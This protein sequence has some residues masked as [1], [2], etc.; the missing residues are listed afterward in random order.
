M[1]DMK[2]IPVIYYQDPHVMSPKWW[3]NLVSSFDGTFGL[4][5]STLE[6][7]LNTIL[8]EYDAFTY[9]V[10]TIEHGW[11]RYVDFRTES[12]YTECI[13]KWSYHD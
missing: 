2:R 9:T 4:T 1:I 13:L 11:S 6:K 7:N 12:G 10:E 5:P 3:R 8:E